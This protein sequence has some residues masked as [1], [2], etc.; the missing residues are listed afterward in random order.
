MKANLQKYAHE[1]SGAIDKR[2]FVYAGHQYPL[3]V[4]EC[5][6]HKTGKHGSAKTTLR[7]EELFTE[8]TLNDI[9]ASDEVFNAMEDSPKYQSFANA[10]ISC[11]YYDARSKEAHADIFAYTED[12]EVLDYKKVKLHSTTLKSLQKFLERI[13]VKLEPVTSLDSLDHT[14]STTLISWSVQDKTSLI[15]L[16]LFTEKN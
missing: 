5:S 13:D 15:G 12:Y 3:K 14:V 2:Y 11:V 9:V 8:R 16:N 1:L 6:T 7:M 10:E 4:L